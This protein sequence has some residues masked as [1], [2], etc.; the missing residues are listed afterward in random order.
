MFFIFFAFFLVPMAYLYIGRRLISTSR[1][2]RPWKAAAWLVMAASLAALYVARTHWGNGHDTP[3]FLFMMNTAYASLGFFGLLFCLVLFRD[4]ALIAGRFMKRLRPRPKAADKE[5]EPRPGLQNPGRRLFLEQSMNLGMVGLSGAL[6]AQGLVVASRPPL[7]ERVRVPIANLSA[8]LE[9]LRIVQITDLHVGPTI[10]HAY[11]DMVTDLV[12]RLR[13]DLVAATGDMVDGRAGYILS[14]VE[15]LAK[16]QAPL[17]KF[18]T[19]GN[20]E[21][22]HGVEEWLKELTRLGFTP[23]L[24]RHQVV[25]RGNG[26]LVLAGVT[27][28]RGEWFAANHFPDLGAALANAPQGLPRILLAHRPSV[29]FDSARAGVD[30]QLSGHTHGGQLFPGHL[31]VRLREPFLSGLHQVGR[32]W[33]YVSRGAGCWGPP[34]RLGAPAEVT[35]ITL[36]RAA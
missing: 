5:S 15:P 24:N 18:Y 28:P 14:D 1:L 7:V 12:N 9:G 13:P 4:A 3:A 8:D 22:Y 16:I 26:R 36:T 21:Y 25:E 10:D 2:S 27:D 29:I 33:V 32:T 31:L 6:T 20:H 30:L 11:V 35:E 34:I 19:T 23:L 17:G